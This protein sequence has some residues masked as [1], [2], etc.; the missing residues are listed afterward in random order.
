MNSV[1]T[2]VHTE[3][4]AG[5][6]VQVKA[7]R[8][9]V[10]GLAIVGFVALIFL[11][12]MLAV[13][14]ARFVPETISRLTG[15]V[16]LS[17]EPTQE[18]E[19]PAAPAPTAT[20]TVT[21]FVPVPATTTPS[22]PT[23]PTPATTTPT[24]PTT[25][26]TGGPNIVT[27]PTYRWVTYP[28][29]P[30]YYGLSDLTVEIIEVGYLRTNSASSFRK[31][32]EVPDGEAGAFRFIVRN[33]G[34]NISGLWRFRAELPTEDNDDDVYSSGWQPSLVPGASK[35]YTLGFDDPEVGNNRRI[36]IEVDYSHAVIESNESNNDDSATID[37]ER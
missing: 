15:A 3:E 26:S 24:T 16:Y 34:T 30:T 32:N 20:T 35:T 18:P 5:D 29:T 12:I 36:D 22:R 11:G 27:Y 6:E 33:K 21:V 1:H 10:N 8:A 13:Y 25:P 7:K 37:V 2:E 9:A 31:D 14:G 4:H 28:T 19:V 17:E 23:T